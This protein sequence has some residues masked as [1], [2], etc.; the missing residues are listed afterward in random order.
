VESILVTGGAGFIGSHFVRYM[1]EKY[2]NYAIRVLD[3]LTYAGNL[4][5][6]T[7]IEERYGFVQRYRF[8]HGD[9][10]DA[11]IVAT[12]MQGCKYVLNFAAESHV[13]RSLEHPGHFVM[14][15]V[16]GTYILLEQARKE[17]VEKFVQISTDEVYGEVLAGNAREDANVAPR[18]PYS[19]SKAGGEFI[20]R[21]YFVTYG[22]PV[23]ITR[24]SNNFGPFQ[25][26][27]KLIPLFIT[28]ALEDRFLPVYGDGQQVRDWIYVLD[29]CRGI[30]VA[31]HQGEIGETYNIGGGNEL[32]NIVITQLILDLLGKPSSLIRFVPDRPGHDRRYALDTTR[33]RQLGWQPQYTFEGAITETISWYTRHE[34]WWK[35]LKTTTPLP[36]FLRQAQTSPAVTW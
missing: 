24:G 27:E 25:Y 32:Q 8:F 5:N 26:P 33:L 12:A 22:L 2:P 10:C 1:L 11:D 17:G 21:A 13:D 31:L 18:S 7:D 34:A 35:P 15:D 23:I 3:K 4:A 9:I 36:A 19:A 16:Y 28:N 14:T 30:D 29:H 6:L 20:A